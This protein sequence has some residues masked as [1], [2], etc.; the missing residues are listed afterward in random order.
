MKWFACVNLEDNSYNIVV[1]T[2]SFVFSGY[3][4]RINLYSLGLA[5]VLELIGYN[6]ILATSCVEVLDCP[7]LPNLN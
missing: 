4:I 2:I 7:H 3:H 1:V 5:A 6:R